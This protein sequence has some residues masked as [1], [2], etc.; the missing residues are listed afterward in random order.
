MME[1]ALTRQVL[2]VLSP[3]S[4]PAATLGRHKVTAGR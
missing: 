1:D 2:R 3:G 4:G